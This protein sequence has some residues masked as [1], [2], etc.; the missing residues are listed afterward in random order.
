[1]KNGQRRALQIL[2]SLTTAGWLFPLWLAV[3]FYLD[4]VRLEVLPL[5]RGQHP[6]NSFPFLSVAQDC[7]AVAIIWLAIVALFWSYVGITRAWPCE[8]PSK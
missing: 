7:F 1:M 5:A 6:L 3:H 2:V 4:F 8:K